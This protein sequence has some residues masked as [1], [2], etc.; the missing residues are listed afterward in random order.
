MKY[1]IILSFF[2]GCVK[3]AN[4]TKPQVEQDSLQ[5]QKKMTT[6]SNS[7]TIEAGNY[8]L[9]NYVEQTTEE[10]KTSFLKQYP[11]CQLESK[12]AQ[13]MQKIVLTKQLS[14][15]EFNNMF[16]NDIVNFISIF[17]TINGTNAAFTGE[18]IIKLNEN[19]SISD[20]EQ[21][22]DNMF[23]IQR[24][25][26]KQMYLVLINKTISLKD[27]ESKLEASNSLKY[28]ERNMIVEYGL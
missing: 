8:L 9:I 6:I 22:F 7:K 25:M 15:D 13:G 23:S 3:P 19:V 11:S 26:T 5:N 18:Y 2:I 12:Q 17:E 21:E 4:E 16:A 24:N 1:L 20:V 27:I 14:I 10:E 28:Y